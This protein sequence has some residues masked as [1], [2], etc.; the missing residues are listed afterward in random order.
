M[1]IEC[2]AKG[3]IGLSD[4]VTCAINAVLYPIS[5]LYDSSTKSLAP[6]FEKALLR[7]FRI[8]DTDSDN[9]LNDVE[10]TKF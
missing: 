9:Y 2:S 7:V 10:L 5:P 8:L 1:G 4:L 3:Y 6:A